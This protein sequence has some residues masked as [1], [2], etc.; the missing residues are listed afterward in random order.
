MRCVMSLSQAGV[1]RFLNVQ[2][3]F[4]RNDP[5]EASSGLLFGGCEDPLELAESGYPSRNPMSLARPGGHRKE[6]L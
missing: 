3:F 6:L 4:G 1:S 5:D 2:V